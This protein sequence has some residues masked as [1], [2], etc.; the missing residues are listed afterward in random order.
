[1]KK[2]MMIVAMISLSFFLSD[3]GFAKSKHK[4]KPDGLLTKTVDGAANVGGSAIKGTKDTLDV[5]L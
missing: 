5:L 3:L 2:V 4:K 1:M